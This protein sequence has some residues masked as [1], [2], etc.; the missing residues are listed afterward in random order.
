MTSMALSLGGRTARQQL[1]LASAAVITRRASSS[2]K[3]YLV[4]YPE[5]MKFF[6]RTSHSF[7][8]QDLTHKRLQREVF[9]EA[10]N[11]F[12]FIDRHGSLAQVQLSHGDQV[13]DSTD[14]LRSLRPIEGGSKVHLTVT[15]VK[16]P[17]SQLP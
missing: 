5:V 17:L 4:E 10:W 7:S 15:F 1:R 16:S 11:L 3:E 9:T 12:P 8:M 14:M 13:V 2:T 6:H